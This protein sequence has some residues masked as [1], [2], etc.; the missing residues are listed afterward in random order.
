VTLIRKT[1]GRSE[2]SPNSPFGT[3]DSSLGAPREVFRP[4]ISGMLPQAVYFWIHKSSLRVDPTR[5]EIIAVPRSLN[6]SG[7]ANWDRCAR[8]YHRGSRNDVQSLRE[9]VD[10]RVRLQLPFSAYL[11]N[12]KDSSVF[13]FPFSKTS[14]PPQ[15]TPV[16]SAP[17]VGPLPR[18]RLEGLARPPPTS[19]GRE[20]FQSPTF[21]NHHACA[22]R[23]FAAPPGTTLNSCL[24]A[25]RFAIAGERGWWTFTT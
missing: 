24:P 10:G 12:S 3:L 4:A 18:I 19:A 16:S 20:F 6:R 15:T 22:S 23:Q 2:T 17:R 14:D 13:V 1:Q 25:P 8:P 9:N 5:A 7:E 21:G 11:F